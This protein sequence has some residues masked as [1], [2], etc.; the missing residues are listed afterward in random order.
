LSKAGSEALERIKKTVTEA[1]TDLGGATGEQELGFINRFS[2]AA[3]DNVQ[4]QAEIRRAK[5]QKAID[6]AK[7]NTEE[8]FTI[9]AEQE[10]R[11][12]EQAQAATATE[13]S[14]SWLQKVTDSTKEVVKYMR[15]CF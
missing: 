1:F 4:A 3:T 6:I 14:Q 8:E 10:I 11:A 7:G 12:Q 15:R 13:A 9:H 2:T 5:W